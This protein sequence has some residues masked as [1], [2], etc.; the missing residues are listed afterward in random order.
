MD[1]GLQRS[2]AAGPRPRRMIP[3]LH[4]H[5]RDAAECIGVIG[6]RGWGR[7]TTY[8]SPSG[9]ARTGAPGSGNCARSG[10]RQ[11]P[12]KNRSR[13]SVS[14]NIEI[15]R[16][17]RT[18]EPGG[19]GAIHAGPRRFKLTRNLRGAAAAPRWAGRAEGGTVAGFW[20]YENPIDQPRARWEHHMRRLRER[21]I[22]RG[23]PST[24]EKR[25]RGVGYV[26]YGRTRREWLPFGRKK[27]GEAPRP[28][29]GRGSS[30]SLR[31]DNPVWIKRRKNDR[32]S[33]F[34]S[35]SA[36]GVA[37]RRWAWWAAASRGWRG[38]T[39]HEESKPTSSIAPMAEASQHRSWPR[40]GGDARQHDS[41]GLIVPRWGARCDH[42]WRTAQRRR[43]QV[44]P[45]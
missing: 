15:E 26:L 2:Y 13:N 41:R 11:G 20:G 42:A 43:C 4:A 5:R 22:R 12:Q 38:K 44:F 29:E 14:A 31:N 8:E 21:K 37:I 45:S 3:I 40:N 16:L 36:G 7:T 25:F 19:R 10:G 17:P 6:T 24:L 34:G 9:P 1:G 27:R 23:P 28:A 35:R 32:A 33:D 39:R 18:G 30:A